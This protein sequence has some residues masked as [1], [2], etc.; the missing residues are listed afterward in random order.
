MDYAI[1]V[2]DIGMTN[3]KLAIYDQ[4]LRQLNAEYRC[5]PPLMLDGLET[6]NLPA[7]ETW[8]LERLA[9][10]A[11]RFPIRAI[12]ISTHGA[13]FVGLDEAGSPCLPCV[14]Y[15]HEPGEAFHERFYT[16]FGDRKTLQAIT[17]TAPFNALI[18]LAKGL[19]FSQEYYP[20]AYSKV[21]HILNYPQYWASRLNGCFGTEGTSVGCHTYL[22]DWERDSW[23]TVAEDLGLNDKMPAILNRP[24][25]TLG[26]ITPDI[27]KK[28]GLR[29]D[30][31]V[32]LGIHDSNASLLP[33]FAKKGKSG[34]V[35]NSTGTWCV[36][37]N[38]TSTYGFLPDELGKVVFYNRSAFNS[39]IKT[40]NF[41]GGQEFETWSSLL[42]AI[43]GRDELPPYDAE[44]Y[45]A[46]LAND[47]YIL[48]ELVPGSGQFPFSTARVSENGVDYTFRDLKA[49]GKRPPCFSSYDRGIAILRVSLVMQTL[50]ALS[51][52]G[53]S[54]GQELYT[55]GGFRKNE[56]YNVL[57]SSALPRNRVFLSDIKEASALG[58]AMTAKMALTGKEL[59]DLSDDFSVDYHEIPK[60]ANAKLDSYR[61]RWLS[62]V[63]RRP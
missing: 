12:A 15:T 44:L 6:H 21:R 3:K 35:L 39:P 37:M 38:P 47:A 51:R 16:R 30:T 43:H 53:L 63:E 56:A 52:S 25:D 59:G 18:N 48:P 40:A 61:K 13:S 27:A 14:Y 4:G 31:L 60:I 34:F 8:Y 7:I 42:M 55:E 50:S 41:L 2:I 36:I 58:A 5:F 9:E 23:S 62:H 11:K 54:D 46:M 26:T 19:M 29:A 32:T 28:T 1:A 49:G 20:K 10:A 57:L 24:W 45:D 17:G 33:H 22:W